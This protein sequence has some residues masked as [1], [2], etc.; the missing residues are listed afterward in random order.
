MMKKF[1]SVSLVFLSLSARA[2]IIFLEDFEGGAGQNEE[3]GHRI[4]DQESHGAPTPLSWSMEFADSNLRGV[5]TRPIVRCSAQTGLFTPNGN[6]YM[7]S[8]FPAISGVGDDPNDGAVHIDWPGPVALTPGATYYMA[9]FIRFQRMGWGNATPAWND[10]DVWRD[11]IG[12]DYYHT[13]KLF[14]WGSQSQSTFRWVI[15]GGWSD[16]YLDHQVN[17]KFEFDAYCGRPDRCGTAGW[18]EGVS[19]APEANVSPY[20]R[21]NAYGVDYEKWHAVVFAVRIGTG[22]T[23]RIQMWVDGVKTHD[24]NNVSTSAS[25]TSFNRIYLTS[26]IGQPSYDHP[27]FKQQTDYLIITDNFSDI[28]NA[29]LMRNPEAVN[30][31]PVPPAAPQGLRI[32]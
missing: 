3:C 30:G 15:T 19:E 12:G 14:D 31:T 2:E 26:T 13:S 11:D 18:P 29:G 16:G 17:H 20:G 23:G 5:D 8:E 28:Q 32:K 1:L 21:T 9:Q 22:A 24:Y 4:I 6:A 25:N 10:N 27:Q 7:E